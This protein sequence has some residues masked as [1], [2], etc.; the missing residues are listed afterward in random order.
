MSESK[1]KDNSEQ[2]TLVALALCMAV[3]FVWS[4]FFAPKPDPAVDATATDGAP[5][6]GATST[7]TCGS[8]GLAAT[9]VGTVV[10]VGGPSVGDGGAVAGSGGNS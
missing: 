2:R 9:G 10:E 3:F 5:V 4:E 6:T 7:L 8:A 1:P